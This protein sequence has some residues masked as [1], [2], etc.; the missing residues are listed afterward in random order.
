[1]NGKII[2]F[3]GCRWAGGQLWIRYRG[4]FQIL[5]KCFRKPVHQTRRSQRGIDRNPFSSVDRCIISTQSLYWSTAGIGWRLVALLSK[6]RC[7]QFPNV[8]RCLCFSSAFIPQG[9][10]TRLRFFQIDCEV[11]SRW[12]TLIQLTCCVAPVGGVM[13]AVS[14]LA[15]SMSAVFRADDICLLKCWT[16]REFLQFSSNLVIGALYFFSH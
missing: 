3:G 7:E 4:S 5:I 11:N 15:I 1:M 6:P 10:F 13:V 8:Y 14:L 12:Q 16:I 2:V 9:P